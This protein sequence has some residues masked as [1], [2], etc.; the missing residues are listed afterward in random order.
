MTKAFKKVISM[1]LCLMMLA[2]VCAVGVVPA[3]AAGDGYTI[4]S[5]QTI[6]VE[7]GKPVYFTPEKTGIYSFYSTVSVYDPYVYLYDSAGNYL[8]YDDDGGDGYNFFVTYGLKA[9][10]KYRYDISLYNGN[11]NLD[12][13]LVHEHSDSDMDGKCDICSVEFAAATS[14]DAPKTL[15]ITAGVVTEYRFTAAATGWY[16]FVYDSGYYSTAD[17]YDSDYNYLGKMYSE[18][19]LIEGRTYRLRLTNDTA[20]QLTDVEPVHRHTDA[21]GDGLCDTDSVAFS[22]TYAL[23]EKKDVTI[24]AGGTAELVFTCPADTWYYFDYDSSTNGYDESGVFDANGVFLGYYDDGFSGKAGE[25][26]R[27]RFTTGGATEIY[28]ITLLHD[29]TDGNGDGICDVCSEEYISTIALGEKKT[30]RVPAGNE[31]ELVFTCEKDGEYEVICES[32]S[33]IWGCE[34]YDSENR[35]I[36]STYDTMNL[37]AGDVISIR[38]YAY[39]SSER[40][41]IYDVTVWHDHTDADSDGI[42]DICSAEISAKIALGEKKTVEIPKDETR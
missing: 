1:A 12:V 6:T 13:T 30:V 42:C 25:T 9:G 35:Y 33:G 22:S 38:F 37:S 20:S 26:Y 31:R 16:M 28:G 8:G 4:T 34:I 11:T 18:V 19:Y 40:A 39:S 27:L 32:S 5:D 7:S 10:E 17:V 29:H 15:D 23:G 24:P 36:G 21:N 41:K 3:V 14:F 2:G